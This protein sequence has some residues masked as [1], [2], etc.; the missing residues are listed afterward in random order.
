MGSTIDVIQCGLY[1]GVTLKYTQLYKILSLKITVI[2]ILVVIELLYLL[3]EVHKISHRA[4]VPLSEV[5][6]ILSYSMNIGI[7]IYLY[8]ISTQYI[9]I[10]IYIYIYMHR[11]MHVSV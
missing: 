10:Y 4:V 11:C 6:K 3:S 8:Y 2:T 1:K 7:V 9:Y 5:H